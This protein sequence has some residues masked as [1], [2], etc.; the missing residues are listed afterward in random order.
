M[1]KILEKIK[2]IKITRT[3]ILGAG[4]CFLFALLI[5]RLYRLQIVDGEKYAENFVLKTKNKL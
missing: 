2:Q 5:G 4:L 1:S 3:M